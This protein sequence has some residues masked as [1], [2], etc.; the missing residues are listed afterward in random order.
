M[1]FVGELLERIFAVGRAL[2]Y[3]PVGDFR[4]EHGKAVV[5][6]RSYGDVLHA[7]GFGESDPGF[8]VKFLRVEEFGQTLVIV[9][10]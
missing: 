3:V 7:G 9:D 1:R 4:V 5:M 10:L 2:N 6:A 8:R